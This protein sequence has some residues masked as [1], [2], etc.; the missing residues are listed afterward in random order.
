[1]DEKEI[2]ILF[3]GEGVDEKEEEI[4]LEAIGT[5]YPLLE[6][7]VEEGAQGLYRWLIGLT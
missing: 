4:L 2:C 3:R 5:K 7:N 1:M 6:I